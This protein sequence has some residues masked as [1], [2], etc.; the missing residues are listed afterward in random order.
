MTLFYNFILFILQILLCLSLPFIHFF[1]KPLYSELLERLGHHKISS[2]SLKPLWI[3]AAS[4]GEVTIAERIINAIKE[5]H[6]ALPIVL[7][8]TTR[9]GRQLAREKIKNVESIIYFPFDFKRTVRTFLDRIDPELLIMIETEIWPNLLWEMGNRKIRC[10]IVNGRISDKS[11]KKYQMI[12]P[13]ISRALQ[14]IVSA[15]MSS[16]LYASRITN[17]GLHSEKVIITGNIKFDSRISLSEE[18]QTSLMN[19]MG[20]HNHYEIFLAGSTAEGEDQAIID[21]YIEVARMCKHP[22][23]LIAPRHIHR[24]SEIEHLLQQKNLT[25]TKLSS[26]KKKECHPHGDAVIIDTIGDLSKIYSF[27]TIIFVGGSLVSKGGHNILEPASFGKPV[28]FGKHMENF[29]EMADAFVKNGAGFVV[30]DAED[31]SKK[32]EYLLTNKDAYRTAG[33]KAREI[34]EENSGSLQKTLREIERVLSAR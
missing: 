22:I 1:N 10:M 20:L 17:L 18:E 8:T 9:T 19:L 31:L 5:K 13:L 26:L 34:F 3:Q 11:Y 4:V 15:C 23:L 25:Y 12:K 14:S 28:L 16:P 6:P 33:Q 2:D 24:T 32:M 7:T 30:H 29:Q 27:G 21:A